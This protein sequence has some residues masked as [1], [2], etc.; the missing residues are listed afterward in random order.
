MALTS[1]LPVLPVSLHGSY[2]AWPPGQPWLHGGLIRVVIDPA[3]ETSGLTQAD[4]NEL[5]DQV[6]DVIAGKLA[7]MGGRVG[8]A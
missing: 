3:I 2:E 8:P 5:R 7:A 1:Q 6:R 4:G